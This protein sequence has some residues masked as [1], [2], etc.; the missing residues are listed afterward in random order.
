MKKFRYRLA[1][2][3][4]IKEHRERERQK[5]HAEALQQVYDQNR[6]LEQIDQNRLSTLNQQ[7]GRLH[8]TL[9]L[10]HLQACSRFLV[11]LKRDTMVGRET[12]RGYQAEAE[13]RRQK[14]VQASQERQIYEK[15][16]EKQQERFVKEIEHL[17]KIEN[18][19]IALQTF[20][21]NQQR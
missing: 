17:E 18:D 2:L 8:G 4:K 11:K 21:L 6:R 5:E 14:L 3:L 19:E 13:K 10:A 7:R 20:R 9:S 15:L 16:K 12:L 1:S